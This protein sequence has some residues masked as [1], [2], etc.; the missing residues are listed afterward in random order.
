MSNLGDLGAT[1]G[2]FSLAFKNFIKAESFQ[3]QHTCRPLHTLVVF[4]IKTTKVCNGLNDS[5]VLCGSY[6]SNPTK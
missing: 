5:V 6:K 1:P 2:P 4:T 3:L